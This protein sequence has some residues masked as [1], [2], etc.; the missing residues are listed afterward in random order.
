MSELPDLPE[1]RM[2]EPGATRGAVVR[3]LLRTA[4][5]AAALL[6]AAKLLGYLV[7][8]VNLSL[9]GGSPRLDRVGTTAFDVGH[10][11][12]ARPNGESRNTGSGW[13]HTTETVQ[14]SFADGVGITFRVRMDLLGRITVQGPQPTALD[15]ALLGGRARPAQVKAFVATLPASALTDVVVD[16]VRPLPAEAVIGLQDRLGLFTSARSGLELPAVFYDDPFAGARRVL[17]VTGSSFYGGSGP[18]RPVSWRGSD[19][20]GF[21]RWTASLRSSDD[22]DLARLGL[23]SSA[24]LRRLG[25]HPRAHGLLISDLTVAQLGALLRDPAVRTLTPVSVRFTILDR[26]RS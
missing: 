12:L 7:G 11:D 4:M 5:L 17:R 6:V 23:P 20:D 26:D 19:A 10:P 1:L 21:H 3:G 16:L 9:H 24:A 2:F 22:G 8:Y 25:D 14:R 15:Q 13:L 18:D